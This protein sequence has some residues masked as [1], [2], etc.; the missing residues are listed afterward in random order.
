MIL[1]GIDH[2][3]YFRVDEKVLS[4][5]CMIKNWILRL[6][7]LIKRT[8]L[9]VEWKTVHLHKLVFLEKRMYF[10]TIFHCS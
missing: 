7:K 9:S 5:M 4:L 10:I 3:T 6:I 2:T 8:F 1:G